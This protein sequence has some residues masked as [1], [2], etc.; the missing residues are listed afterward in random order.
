MRNQIKELR[1]DIAAS[2]F[3]LP[4]TEKE[5]NEREFLKNI[6]LGNVQR[7]VMQLEKEAIYYK[8]DV[9]HIKKVWAKENL[10]EYELDID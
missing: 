2:L 7:F 10:K 5:L 1:L 3:M 6:S 9:I 8:G 4:C